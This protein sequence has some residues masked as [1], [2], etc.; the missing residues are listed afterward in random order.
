MVHKHHHWCRI[1]VENEAAF[2]R[3]NVDQT[4]YHQWC[5]LHLRAARGESLGPDEQ[6]SYSA[7]RRE[8]EREEQLLE[9]TEVRESREQL[10]ALEAGHADLETRRQ[11]LDAEIAELESRL[12][13]QTRQYLGVEG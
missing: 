9:T 3:S 5:Q 6:S 7:G 13:D 10:V 11:Q 1:Q 12:R 8:L 4:S 2:R